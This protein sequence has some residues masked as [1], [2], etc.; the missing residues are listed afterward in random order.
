MKTRFIFFVSA[1]LLFGAASITHS[2]IEDLNTADLTVGPSLLEITDSLKDSNAEKR[3]NLLTDVYPL[4]SRSISAE[5]LNKAATL[6]DLIEFYPAN[7]IAAYNT[8]LITVIENGEEKTFTSKNE[9]LTA[10]QMALLAKAKLGS[11]IQI[12]VNFK[13]KNAITGELSDEQL[14]IGLT[15][16]PYKN[17]ELTGGKK[18]FIKDL[19]YFFTTNNIAGNY[20][21]DDLLRI[22]FTVTKNGTVKKTSIVNSSG[23]SKLDYILLEMLQKNWTWHPAESE[24]GVKIPCELQF[25]FGDN[26]IA[27]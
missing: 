24:N 5:A 7:W 6:K 15:V 9:K 14:D 20:M 3:I 13:A 11:N 25:I 26:G 19:E 17:A 21:I 27:C 1:I 23:D 22:N 12:I 16:G 18:T 8:V 10:K 4:H 2:S